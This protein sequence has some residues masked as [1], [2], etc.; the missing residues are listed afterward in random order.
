MVALLPY[1]VAYLV[2]DLIKTFKFDQNLHLTN[3]KV[4]FRIPPLPCGVIICCAGPP[5]PLTGPLNP[6]NKH[7]MSLLTYFNAVKRNKGNITFQV[8]Q[9]NVKGLARKDRTI[10]SILLDD[11][12][13]LQ[14]S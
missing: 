1:L 3:N 12:H 11:F 9:K 10:Q 2:G 14:G 6:K 8:I 4:T 13:K 5:T 7:L